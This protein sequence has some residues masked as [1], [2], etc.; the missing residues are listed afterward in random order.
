MSMDHNTAIAVIEAHRDGKEIEARYRNR[1]QLTNQWTECT[2]GTSW[3]FDFFEYRIKPEPPKPRE[4]WLVMS[5]DEP[6]AIRDC[7]LPP[8]SKYQPRVHVREVLP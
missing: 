6:I 5:G 3:N 8:D 4:W 2:D 1:P 7:Q